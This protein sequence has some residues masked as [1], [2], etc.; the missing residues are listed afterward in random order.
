LIALAVALTVPCALTA[1]DHGGVI[2]QVF[3][4]PLTATSPHYVLDMVE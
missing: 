2:V 4:D 1:R 3:D